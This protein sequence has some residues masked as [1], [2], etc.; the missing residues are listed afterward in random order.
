MISK[1]RR[2]ELKNAVEI[3]KENTLRE[4]PIDKFAD[5]GFEYNEEISTQFR[6]EC[7]KAQIK[8]WFVQHLMVFSKESCSS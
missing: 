7:K 3:Q 4:Y 5:K 1:L 8:P 2:T 6:A